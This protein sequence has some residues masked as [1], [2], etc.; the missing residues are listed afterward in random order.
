[1]E[2]SFEFCLYIVESLS[3]LC[4]ALST[5]FGFSF[6]S[7]DRCSEGVG[8]EEGGI[9]APRLLLLLSL[10]LVPPH[11]SEAVT[12]TSGGGGNKADWEWETNALS[13]LPY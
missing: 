2:I 10:P 4:C 3:L 12:P 1:M 13:L 11:R 9:E 5:N 6:F 7:L 8:D